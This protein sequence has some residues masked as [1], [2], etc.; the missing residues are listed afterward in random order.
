VFDRPYHG[1]RLGKSKFPTNPLVCGVL[2]RF[3]DHHRHFGDILAHWGL[4]VWAHTVTGVKLSQR[5]ISGRVVLY[6]G[7]VV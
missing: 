1:V 4:N 5:T 6:K 3:T 2:L 7:Q